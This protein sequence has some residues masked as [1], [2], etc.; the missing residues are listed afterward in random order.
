V[1]S[2]DITNV[3][4]ED[5]TF[6]VVQIVI[7]D[8]P[9]TRFAEKSTL[10]SLILEELL[11]RKDIPFSEG[12]FKQSSG[13]GPVLQGERYRVLGMGKADVRTAERF[14]RLYDFS[15]DYKIPID[16]AHVELLRA[17]RPEWTW[18]VDVAVPY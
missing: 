16:V 1:E 6:K 15:Y 5:G 3:P 8:V 14:V 18:S 17:E 12:A 10:H 2:R 13:N 4:D 9:Y 11:R 7:D